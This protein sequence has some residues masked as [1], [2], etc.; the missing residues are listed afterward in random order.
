MA[1]SQGKAKDKSGNV[2][3]AEDGSEINKTYFKLVSVFDV[4][5]TDLI[6]EESEVKKV[7]LIAV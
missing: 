1:P 5:Q 7:E 2:R 6:P 4:S 3:L